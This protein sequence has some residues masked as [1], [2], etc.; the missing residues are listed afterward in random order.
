MSTQTQTQARK[1]KK[2]L[3]SPEDRPETDVVIYDGHCRICTGGVRILYRLDL[4][5][6]LSFLSL[7]DAKVAEVAPNLTHDQM[8]EEMWVVDVQGRQHSGA[9]AFRYLTRRIAMLWPVMPLLH[10][11]GSLP[12]WSWLY[13]K[14]AAARYRFGKNTGEDCGDACAIHFGP[15]K[16]SET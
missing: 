2:S 13:Q 14:V 1:E 6:R 5:R 3:P 10:I 16:N 12:L 15:K 8:M 11:P 9:G 4:G 7:H